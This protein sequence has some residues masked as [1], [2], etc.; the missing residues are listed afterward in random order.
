MGFSLKLFFEE[1]EELLNSDVKLKK[2]EKEL[3]MLVAKAK[4][5]AKE[6]GQI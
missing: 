2:K 4:K 3:I 1:L 6:C 5:Y